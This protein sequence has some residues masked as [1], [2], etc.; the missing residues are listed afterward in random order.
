MS[1]PLP[2]ALS[3]T[4]LIVLAV[5]FAAMVVVLETP[6][7]LTALYGVMSV[8]AFFAYGFDKSAALQGGRRVSE[9]TLLTLGLLGGWPGALAA[10]QIFRHKTRKRS[11]RRRFWARVL[12]NVVLL[13]AL[14][15]V[16]SLA[17][18]DIQYG[19]EFIVNMF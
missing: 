19:W 15:V 18:W 13:A 7:W 9:Q 1:R 11:F 10:Q 2:A 16:T 17:G 5:A 12:G 6:R 14:V 8:I 3:W 4:V